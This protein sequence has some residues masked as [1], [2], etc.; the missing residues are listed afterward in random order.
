MQF[1]E[2]NHLVFLIS[3]FT[4]FIETK[5]KNPKKIYYIDHSLANSINTR[6]LQGKLIL[7]Y[8][9]LDCK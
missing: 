6:F 8:L 4:N 2:E 7:F 1:F 9:K 5:Q 3:K